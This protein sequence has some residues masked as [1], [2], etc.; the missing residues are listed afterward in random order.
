[1]SKKYRLRYQKVTVEF[2]KNPR[3]GKCEACKKDIK[4][5]EI[6]RT[7][8]HHYYYAYHPSTV[9]KN[10]A[11]ALENTIEVCYAD[12]QISDSLR[13][14][15]GVD[16]ERVAKVLDIHPKWFQDRIMKLV[17]ILRYEDIKHNGK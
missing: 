4:K 10:P 1:M 8:I 17:K 5:G 14:L 3:T 12:H 6:K 2:P 9:L 16:P 13:V 15:A 11:L 7:N